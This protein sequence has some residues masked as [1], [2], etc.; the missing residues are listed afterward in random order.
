MVKVSDT[1]PKM[2][3]SFAPASTYGNN[4]EEAKLVQTT[5]TASASKSCNHQLTIHT[6]DTTVDELLL[7]LL[8]LLMVVLVV[9]H[10]V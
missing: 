8:L 2:A 5:N 4:T 9:P 3:I 1:A 7:L 6:T 10:V